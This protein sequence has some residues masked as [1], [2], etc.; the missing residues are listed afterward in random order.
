MKLEEDQRQVLENI[1][2][3]LKALC[4]KDFIHFK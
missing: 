3:L 1:T 2:S 4:E